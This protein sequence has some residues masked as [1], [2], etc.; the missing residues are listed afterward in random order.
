MG[1]TRRRQEHERQIGQIRDEETRQMICGLHIE[2]IQPYN[3]VGEIPKGINERNTR[4]RQ[5]PFISHPSSH[6][7]SRVVQFRYIY[8]PISRSLWRR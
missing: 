1:L 4:G 7:Y 3:Y 6:N 8:V 2:L 5:V